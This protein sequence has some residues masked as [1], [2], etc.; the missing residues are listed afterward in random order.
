MTT[1]PEAISEL[2]LKTKTAKKPPYKDTYIDSIS[3]SPCT[4]KEVFDL[5]RN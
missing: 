4:R 5:F 1:F 3:L 2:K